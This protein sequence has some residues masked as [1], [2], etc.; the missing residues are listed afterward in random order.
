MTLPALGPVPIPEDNPMS[1]AKVN[2]GH[3]LFSTSA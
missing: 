2:L 1:E 3:Q